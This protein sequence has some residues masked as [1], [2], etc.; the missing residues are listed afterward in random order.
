MG[1]EEEVPRV[2][3][4]L[5]WGENVGQFEELLWRLSGILGL[6]DNM[7]ERLGLAKKVWLVWWWAFW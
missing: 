4:E 6:M 2:I 7:K 5:T 3:V 1:G